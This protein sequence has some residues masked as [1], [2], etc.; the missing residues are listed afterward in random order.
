MICIFYLL[1]EHFFIP[2]N[3]ERIRKWEPGITFV[4]TMYVSFW[5]ADKLIN[6]VVVNVLVLSRRANS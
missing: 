1:F 4:R 2:G 6:S 3:R 5:V